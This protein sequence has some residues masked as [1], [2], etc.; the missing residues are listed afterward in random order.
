MFNEQTCK[1]CGACLSQCPVME[2]PPEQARAEI[3][4]MVEARSFSELIKDCIG[5][6]YCDTICP[7]Q[8]NPSALRKEIME[9]QPREPGISPMGMICEDVPNNM[10]AIALKHEREE[11]KKI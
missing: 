2:M 1:Q 5:C 8:S 7:T 11:K 9:Q 10:M 3:A 6:S 4:K